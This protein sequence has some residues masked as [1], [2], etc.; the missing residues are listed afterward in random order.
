M[1]P[2]DDEIDWWDLYQ[3]KTFDFRND[4]VLYDKIR[5]AILVKQE[6]TPSCRIYDD[7]KA[8]HM[9]NPEKYN[10]MNLDNL[11]S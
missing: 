3:N 2:T 4:S 1:Y 11:K 5:H 8:D 6:I 7:L 10:G 9:D